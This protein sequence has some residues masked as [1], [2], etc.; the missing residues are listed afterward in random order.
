MYHSIFVY[1]PDFALIFK[2]LINRYVFFAF[3]LAFRISL[4]NFGYLAG[5]F[6][7]VAAIF[8]K[9]VL[10]YRGLFELFK[11]KISPNRVIR[12][13]FILYHTSNHIPRYDEMVWFV[14][15]SFFKMAPNQLSG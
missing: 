14:V 3:I 6:D 15:T 12:V 4:Q 1:V 7:H 8:L 2:T 9:K 13:L 10:R 11:L 5:I